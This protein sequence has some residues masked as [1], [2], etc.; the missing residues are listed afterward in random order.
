MAKSIIHLLVIFLCQLAASLPIPMADAAESEPK[1]DF[2]LDEL[3]RATKAYPWETKG[4]ELT[5]ETR[6]FLESGQ[7]DSFEQQRSFRF[8]TH[9]EKQI[10]RGEIRAIISGRYDDQDPNRNLFWAEDLYI[11]K[12]FNE[13]YELLAG[14]K[15]FNF[16]ALEA[17]A[18]LDAINARIF[19]VSI[20]NAEKMGELAFG[21]SVEKFEGD[22]SF[23]LIPHP[24][25]PILPGKNSRINLPENLDDAV[26]M[27]NTD[28]EPDWDDHFF[29]SWEGILKDWDTTFLV[30]K[31]IDRTSTIVGTDNYTIGFGNAVPKAGQ[32]KFNTPY[33]YERFLMG[34]NLVGD[35]RDDLIK[36]SVAH[37]YYLSETEIYSA[38]MALAASTDPDDLQAPQDYTVIATGYE[39]PISFDNGLS[40]S[41]FIEHQYMKFKGDDNQAGFPLAND[42]FAAWRVDFNDINSKQITLS[43]MYDLEGNQE[44]FVQLDYSQRY[45]ENFRFKVGILEYIIPDDSPFTGYGIFRDTEHLYFN[46]TYYL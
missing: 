20:V 37:S 35:W 12:N 10:D 3:E 27:G 42:I 9:W 17:F 21:V 22:L 13:K 24:T 4:T 43:G 45:K 28:D 32:S 18:P 8:K 25:R 46:L 39:H 40:S 30:S 33:Y 23:Y 16:A 6:Q 5:L 41:L 44:G 2:E 26:W 14:F 34:V 15:T 19:D 31:N 29:I 7:G 11:T 36:I 1:L 38:Q